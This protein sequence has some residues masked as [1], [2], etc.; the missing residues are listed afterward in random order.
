MGSKSNDSLIHPAAGAAIQTG[1]N[2]MIS[3]VHPAELSTETQQTSGSLRMSAI[4]ATHGIASSLWAGIFGVEPS[5]RTGIH[6]HGQQDAVVYVLEGEAC[7]RWGESGE[8]L[9]TVGAGDFLHVPRGCHIRRST[10]RK[11]ILSAGGL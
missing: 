7:V 6:H 11:R 4:A 5:A 1:S 9:A 3:V 10:L 2:S 8:H